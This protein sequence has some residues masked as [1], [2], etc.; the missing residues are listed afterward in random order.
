M[1]AGVWLAGGA[2]GLLGAQACSDTFFQCQ[3]NEQCPDGQ[4]ERTGWCSFPDDDCE[5]GQR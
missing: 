5:S 3:A 1:R 2:L 4:C